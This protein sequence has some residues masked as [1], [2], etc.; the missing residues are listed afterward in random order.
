MTD[1]SIHDDMAG[2]DADDP[3][4]AEALNAYVAETEAGRRPLRRAF[5]DRYPQLTEQLSACLDGL[6]FVQSAAGQLR[7]PRARHNAAID[8]A[9]AKP[10]GDFRL[11][12]QIGRGGMGVVY[13][14]EQISLGRRVALKVLPLA[15]AM[16]QR[17]L[18]RFHNEAQAAA[19][20]H[21]TNV[22]PVYA[23]GCE[24]SVH[25][26]AM[27]LIEGQS[28]ADVIRDLK[29]NHRLS[30]EP[31]ASLA[32][33][34]TQQRREFYR[35]VALLGAQAADG[36]E[37]A[38][39]MGVVHRDIKPGNLLLDHAGTLWIA[40]FGL[41]QLHSDNAGEGLTRSGDLLGT[42]R[43]MS[44]E[45]ASGRAVLLDQRTD[46]Y[47][48][49]ATLFELV[50]LRPAMEGETQVE[51]LKQIEQTDPPSACAID[52]M[53]PQQL[54]VIMGQAL[55]KD[56]AERYQDAAAMAADLRRFLND[57][58][59][60]ARPM[61]IRQKLSRWGRRHRRGVAIGVGLLMLFTAGLLVATLLIAQANHR[62][63]L[64][65]NQER[66]RAIQ[67]EQSYQ[68]AREVVDLLTRFAAEELADNPMANDERRAM[69][70][71]AMVY[72]Q[73]FLDERGAA[74]DD[75]EEL[76]QAR[77]DLNVLLEEMNAREGLRRAGEQ[78]E[79]LGM[80]VVRRE[81]GLGPDRLQREMIEDAFSLDYP[82][83]SAQTPSQRCATYLSAITQ[84]QAAIRE[85]LTPEEA[86]RLQ[87]ITWQ[88][89]GA[90]AMADPVMID[91]LGLS[92]EQQLQINAVLSQAFDDWKVFNVSIPD[93]PGP[94]PQ[95][96]DD[97]SSRQL[98]GQKIHA[99]TLHDAL[100]CLTSEQREIW[101][102]RIGEPFARDDLPSRIGSGMGPI[103][104][105]ERGKP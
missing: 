104:G 4:L 90:R 16:D 65:Y 57:Q 53:I 34:R 9:T 25:Y 58:P 27:Q 76:A 36:L 49:G 22:V 84:G 24:R 102:Q 97:S 91:D 85:H 43:Y 7:D 78:A 54:A 2:G 59:I 70:T 15:A 14:A 31:S 12:R 55:A 81:L 33:L 66:A 39:R 41:A 95:W 86:R 13:E 45:Q 103:F 96:R 6:A 40:D 98:R 19:Q 3:L 93:Q 64:A 101:A 63:K 51:L 1:R 20:L 88:V 80:R 83:M 92:A 42:L 11:I 100:Q 56:P 89:Q 87:Q 47:A 28:L 72:Y 94:S 35:A 50:T 21:H 18:H 75:A 77:E 17:Q 26:Y 60:K 71:Q 61:S 48:L 69:L 79:L 67:A 74:D 29:T 73:Q 105:S 46:V 38:H 52:P 30:D 32:T 62:V 8:P 68:Q 5:L 10:L 37:Y 82:A 99:K 23:V 44:P